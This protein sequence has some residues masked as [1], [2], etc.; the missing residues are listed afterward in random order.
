MSS[1]INAIGTAVPRYRIAQADIAD[2]MVSA[3]GLGGAEE[4]R[5]TALYRASGIKYRHSVL[6]DFDKG[7]RSVFFSKNTSLGTSPSMRDRM[8]L[9]KQEALNL[10]LAAVNDCIQSQH[11]ILK[12]DIT[13]L[14]SVSCTGMYA[15]G[16]DV[17]LVTALGLSPH[18]QRSCV[19]FMGCYAAFNA[20]KI[21]HHIVGA[22]PEASVLIVC[23]ELCTIHF[24]ND[25]DED[26]ILANAL[27]ADG[28][29]AILVSGRNQKEHSQ[30]SMEKFHCSLVP[31]GKQ[32]MAWQLGNFG[33]EMKLSS[34]VP[35]IISQG[36]S[37]LTGQL[38]QKLDDKNGK[39]EPAYYAIHPGGKRILEV[40]E[41][42]L[43]LTR[44]DNRYAY[45][46]LK[47][48]GNMSSPTVTFV[49]KALMNDLTKADAGKGILS[50]AFGPG[51][52]LE[53]MFLKIHR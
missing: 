44:E 11:K 33:F 4:R 42:Q 53:S 47:Q 37:Q 14:I 15:P 8:E 41:E 40:I 46:V 17:E 34:Y 6:P 28:A 12:K 32:D 27:F 38:M 9:Y 22:D 1:F 50:F 3:L 36:I 24:Q 23:T 20:L 51:L 16:V 48:Y 30:L 52:T 29:S 13:H 21:A 31:G 45:Q 43:G 25:N 7:E 18:V 2:F 10:S 35:D 19:N 5:L 49:L 26:V 39:W